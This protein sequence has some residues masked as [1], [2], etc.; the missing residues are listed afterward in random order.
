MSKST[1]PGPWSPGGYNTRGFLKLCHSISRLT[2]SRQQSHPSHPPALA[3]TPSTSLPLHPTHITGLKSTMADNNNNFSGSNLDAS[4]QVGTSNWSHSVQSFYGEQDQQYG[5]NHEEAEDHYDGLGSQYEYPTPLLRSQTHQGPYQHAMAANASLE[6]DRFD[7]SAF[8]NQT[9]G[10]APSAI[11]YQQADENE[12]AIDDDF[13]SY[14]PA[15][16]PRTSAERKD[17]D[18]PT[19]PFPERLCYINPLK[20]RGPTVV[21]P[22]PPKYKDCS[23]RQIAEWFQSGYG[24]PDMVNKIDTVP[25]P[26]PQNREAGKSTPRKARTA[27]DSLKNRFSLRNQRWR[28]VN[29]VLA[30]PPTENHPPSE[31]YM[32]RLVELSN[33][34]LFY[35]VIGDLTRGS[36]T[37]TAPRDLHSGADANPSVHY[38]LPPPADVNEVVRDTLAKIGRDL[39]TFSEFLGR[40]VDILLHFFPGRTLESFNDSADSEET[41]ATAETT[42]KGKNQQGDTH[43][44]L[45]RSSRLKPSFSETNNDLV[46]SEDEDGHEYFTME[47]TQNL[48]DRGLLAPRCRSITPPSTLTTRRE[49]YNSAYDDVAPRFAL[50]TLGSA[51]QEQNAL[52][53]HE[54]D[55]GEMGMENERSSD[56]TIAASSISQFEEASLR[57]SSQISFAFDTALDLSILHHSYQPPESALSH[58]AS[59]H[60]FR[61]TQTP[62]SLANDTVGTTPMEQDYDFEDNGDAFLDAHQ[63]YGL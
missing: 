31:L 13:K 55:F 27:I 11:S 16:G 26:Q 34:Q 7:L 12:G 30:L 49:S 41:A 8:P 60:P 50:S 19:T 6:F 25:L 32:K 5:F 57:D 9:I 17:W 29:G 56:L 40:N 58:S 4:N 10:S 36:F 3:S 63:E 46:K 51:S 52:M 35:G 59:P 21:M 45:R 53:S 24:L 28:Q 38:Q 37:M 47:E 1:L 39:P 20:T 48:I 54:Y 61:F 44:P 2:N 18:D 62:P 33:A 23:P 43:R 15:T 14:R 22:N 42:M